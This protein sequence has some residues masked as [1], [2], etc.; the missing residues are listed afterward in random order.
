VD[1]FASDQAA[2]LRRLLGQAG[3]QVITVMSGQRDAGKTAAT[4]NLGAALASSGRDVLIIDQD[5]RGRGATAAL[6]LQ[7]RYW[8]R[9]VLAG[10]CAPGQLILTA[11]DH[12]HVLPVGG[13]LERLA[14]LPQPDRESLLDG[15]GR[16]QCGVDVVLVDMEDDTDPDTLSPGLAAS[17]V[18]IVLPPGGE[19][20]TRAYG[21]V[22]RLASLYGK[23]QFRLL[24]NRM[25]SVEQA[26]AV[27]DNFCLTAERY[28][29]VSVDYLGCIPID[30]RLCRASH[31][32]TSVVE[33]FPVALS[34]SQFRKLADGLLRWSQ[35][36]G[37]DG[38]AGFMQGLLQHPRVPEACRR[39]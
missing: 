2:G 27:A 14:V 6:G 29:G 15:F 34:T 8:M 1:K 23:R 26:Q 17:E 22:K 32:H 21:L 25:A 10:R 24:L 33:A 4:I 13:G 38:V 9:D 7:P 11:Q 36:L 12:L 39:L 3:L 31:L 35:P 16:L 30:E 19:A 20:I 5:R 37:L 28:L 18:M